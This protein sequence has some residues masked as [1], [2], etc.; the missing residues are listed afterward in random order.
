MSPGGKPGVVWHAMKSL[1][2]ILV[3]GSHTIVSDMEFRTCVGVNCPK[4]WHQ[5]RARG[6]GVWRELSMWFCVHRS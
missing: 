6:G 2:I 3:L 4:A 1:M 5:R